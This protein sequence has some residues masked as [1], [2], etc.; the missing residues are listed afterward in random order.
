MSR[1]VYIPVCFTET[2]FKRIENNYSIIP[3]MMMMIMIVTTTTII[4]HLKMV[5]Y[6]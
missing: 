6:S 4:I 3:I 1:R 5:R 2:D